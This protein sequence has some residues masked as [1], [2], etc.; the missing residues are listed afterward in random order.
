METTPPA[1][2]PE[3]MDTEIVMQPRTPLDTTSLPTSLP[4]SLLTP[5]ESRE[6]SAGEQS[7]SATTQRSRT[8]TKLQGEGQAHREAWLHHMAYW[9]PPPL[10]VLQPFHLWRVPTASAL[11]PLLARRGLPLGEL[12]RVPTIYPLHAVGV[13]SQRGCGSPCTPAAVLPGC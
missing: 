12:E 1:P 10:V 6:V 5:S 2:S 9:D 3:W 13:C 11:V 8:C 7:W 4:P